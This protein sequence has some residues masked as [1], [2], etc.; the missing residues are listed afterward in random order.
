MNVTLWGVME[1]ACVS[2]SRMSDK[3]AMEHAMLVAILHHHVGTEVGETDRQQG[4][5]WW[6]G[7]VGEE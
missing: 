4:G 6:R 1:K 2:S 5:G 3:F 7:E